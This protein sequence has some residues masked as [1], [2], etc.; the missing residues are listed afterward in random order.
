MLKIKKIFKTIRHITMLVT[1][2]NLIRNIF[3][4]FITLPALSMAAEG[5]IGWSYQNELIAGYKLLYAP[6]PMSACSTL[7]AS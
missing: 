2:L 6:S 5:T 4:F 3:L 1:P 7:R